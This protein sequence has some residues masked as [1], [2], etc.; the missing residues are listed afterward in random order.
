MTQN[1]VTEAQLQNSAEKEVKYLYLKHRIVL[2]DAED[3]ERIGSKGWYSKKNGRVERAARKADGTRTSQFIHQAIMGEAPEGME[4][5]H[6]NRMPWDNRKANL[7]FVTRSENLFN[8][9][10]SKY[11]TTGYKGVRR[12]HNGYTVWVGTS[13]KPEN[14]K[15]YFK[16]LEDAVT[17]RMNHIQELGVLV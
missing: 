7:R 10:I 2:V 6:I 14:Y 11:N 4:V 5:D 1:N 12:S 17:V 8:R 13:N 16:S 9:G 15:G 3:L